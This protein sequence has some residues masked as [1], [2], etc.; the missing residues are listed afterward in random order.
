MS[1]KK[2]ATTAMIL[3]LCIVFQSFKGISVFV[4]GSAVNALLVLATLSVGL[5]GGLFIAVMT[6]IIAYF[7]GQTPIM[8][9]LPLMIFVVMLGNATLVFLVGMA[10]GKNL[11]R[12]M[13][14][15]AVLK[16]A[17]LWILVWFVVLPFFGA[18]VPEK[19]QVAVKATF[20]VTQLVTA[21]IGCAL[22]Y[23]IH[24]RVKFLYPQGLK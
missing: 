5:G 3:A 10:K 8:Q 21:L 6:P 24:A 1:T 22:A 15:G 17:V 2:I 9:L 16:A 11:P 23:V 13:L 20:S 18:D 7:L 4:T 14:S 12:W 19:M